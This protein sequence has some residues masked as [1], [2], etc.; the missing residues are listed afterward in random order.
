MKNPNKKPFSQSMRMQDNFEVVGSLALRRLFRE[1]VT[2]CI[3]GDPARNCSTWFIIDKEQF[4]PWTERR[5]DIFNYQYVVE[6]TLTDIGRCVRIHAVER[7]R[8]P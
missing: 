1:H 3:A 2:I 7:T 5:T 8:K 6:I 4:F